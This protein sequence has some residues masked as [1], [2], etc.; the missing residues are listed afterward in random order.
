MIAGHLVSKAFLE[1]H[2]RGRPDAQHF[3]ER[4]HLAPWRAQCAMLGPASGL[5]AMVESGVEPLVRLLGFS[6]LED[7]RY[8]EHAAAAVLG[9]AR[10]VAVV[11]TRWAEPLDGFWR[12]AVVEARSRRADWCLL[13][14]GL[15]LRLL[16]A[17]RVY[18]RRCVHLDLDE[19]ADEAQAGAALWAVCGAPAFVPDAAG[20]APIRRLVTASERHGADVCR[21]LRAGVLEAS[22]GVTQA[23]LSR[24]PR[25]PSGAFEQAL[26]VVY[27]IL[28]LLFAEARMLVPIWHPIYRHSYSLEALRESAERSPAS[29]G[30]W[31]ALRAVS[32]MAHA[33]CQAGDLRVTAFNGRL[34]AA[35]RT[36]L[37]ERRDLDNQAIGRAVLSLGT[38]PA[39]D[40]GGRERISYG[41][42]GVEQLGAV[43]EA[44]LDYAP[45]VERTGGTVRVSLQHGSSQRKATGSFYTP[46]P[47][48]HYLV[49]RALAP[50]VDEAAPERILELKVLDPAMGSGAF[51][52]AACDYLAGA[53]ENALVRA[54]GCHPSDLGPPERAAIRRR[55]AERC[56]FGV[57][58]NPMA[59]Q[60][61]RLSLWL[62]TL[63][64]DRPLTFLDHHL[65][66]GD[67]LLGVWLANL[68]DAPA[69]R[70]SM[71]RDALPLFDTPALGD[72]LRQALPARFTLATVA[73]DTVELVRDKERLLAA[74]SGRDGALAKWKR[75]ADVWCASWF[76]LGAPASAFA[77]LSD[78]VLGG[79]SALQAKVAEPMLQ[80]AEELA[81]ARRFFHWELEFPE[82]FFD[83]RG[84]RLSAPGFD[85]IVGNPPWDMIRADAGGGDERA[86]AR[87]DT[88]A[89]VRF[90]REA[91][92]YAAQSD[93]HAN[94]YQL[95][96]ERVLQLTCR[97]GRLGL[98]LPSGVMADHGSAR[99]R[100][101]LFSQSDVDAIVGFDNRAG[102]FAIHRS[103]RFVLLTAT[104]GR[105]T[106]EIACR[107]GERHPGALES[108]G[109]ET[110]QAWYPVRVTPAL[111]E[112]L[113]GP[114]IALPDLIARIDLTI[115]ERAATLFG[116]LGD[117]SGWAARFG[118]ELNATEDR[119]HL[120]PA[121]R[122]LPVIEGKHLEPFSV[123]ADGARWSISPKDAERLLG[124]RHRRWRLA[125]RDV[126]SATNRTT[127]IASLL[128]P[129]TVTTHTVF[130][131]RT[132][133]PRDAQHFL[134]ALF[135]SL[136]VNYLVRL[137]VATHVTTAIVERLPIPRFDDAPD[138][139]EIAGI[140][141]ALGGEDKVRLKADSTDGVSGFSRTS[142]LARL[143]ALVADLYQLN[144]GEFSHVLATFPLVPLE[145]REAALQEFQK[146][147]VCAR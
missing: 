106:G 39:A 141:K 11:V 19:A 28:F 121:G 12:I 16:D 93:G 9:A 107:L 23:M 42:L 4:R 56:L 123:D 137:R 128:P 33:G 90:T 109:S 32:R 47:L 20:A 45:R 110:D 83:A 59:V 91:G 62:S 92:V 50:L 67:S 78:H 35:A 138:A 6:G 8:G 95:F 113:T 31:E 88:S 5:R 43:Y 129:G 48:A 58:L 134:C 55:I 89:V 65:Q 140:G 132:A 112:R 14:N 136:V 29:P 146:R 147:R 133:L 7:L 115:A 24:Q 2:L 79:R 116:P 99:L 86:R 117:R 72:A 30:L 77:A 34:F 94:R 85:A 96:L 100:Q 126:A 125:Y 118:R 105:P 135:N 22:A 82:A 54:G 102:V 49:R 73:A 144:E 64:A 81:A 130:C 36:P 114:E 75:V 38:R 142:A 76:G 70:R 131:L 80:R 57:D 108:G 41:D 104:R 61:A 25:D 139:A 111:L 103:I 60:L 13:F 40:R 63:A 97:G 15:H 52:V 18:S 145:V 143:N 10:T 66:T 122:G 3:A 21:G 119:R 26:T 71:N 74:T 127:L 101:L 68:R 27:R 87:P 44:L 84:D 124:A 51:L 69:R 1:R 46:Q 53:Y 120:L 37:A 17:E 98:V